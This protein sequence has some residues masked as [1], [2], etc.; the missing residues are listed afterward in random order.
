MLP[1]SVVKFQLGLL[2]VCQN[3]IQVAAYVTRS[4]EAPATAVPEWLSQA[5]AAAAVAAA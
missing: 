5:A 4:G 1:V 3:L 2:Q